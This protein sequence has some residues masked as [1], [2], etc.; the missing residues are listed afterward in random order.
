M[1]SDFNDKLTELT[2]RINGTTPVQSKG[3]K[4]MN[5]GVGNRRYV[6]INVENSLSETKKK[7]NANSQGVYA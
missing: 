4:N 5:R 7:E 1:P 6:L 3:Q 2:K